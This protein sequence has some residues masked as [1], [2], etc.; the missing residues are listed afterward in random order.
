M[1]TARLDPSVRT[2]LADR[3]G[4]RPRILAWA[5]TAQGWAVGL[6]GTLAVQTDGEWTFQPWHEIGHGGWDAAT[7]RLRWEDVDGGQHE[8]VLQRAGRFPD[9]FNE[10]VT[11]SI[12]FT[13]RVPVGRDRHATVTLRRDLGSDAGATTWRVTPGP[14]V[15]LTDAAVSEQL[16]AALQEARN[17]FS[18][19]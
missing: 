16:E 15:D 12:V 3:L 18:I 17:D 9:L 5:R 4:E 13:R 1:L 6:P 2:S 10:R 19:S 8:L 14:G 7:G 11:S